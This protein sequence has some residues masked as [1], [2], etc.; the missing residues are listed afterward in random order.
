MLDG[1]ARGDVHVRVDVGYAASEFHMATKI[2]NLSLLLI[3]SA[4]LRTKLG[5]RD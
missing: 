4:L 2:S 3:S 5:I 1:L